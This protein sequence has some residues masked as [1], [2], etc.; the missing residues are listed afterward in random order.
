MV[1]VAAAPAVA[2][3]V[4]SSLRCMTLLVELIAA[5]ASAPARTQNTMQ[6]AMGLQ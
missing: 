1:A 6:G 2:K 5:F 3:V 4:K